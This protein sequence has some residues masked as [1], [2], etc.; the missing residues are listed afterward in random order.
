MEQEVDCCCKLRDHDLW[1]SRRDQARKT[2]DTDGFIRRIKRFSLEG[3][4]LI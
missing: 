2:R 1:E 3:R 4:A